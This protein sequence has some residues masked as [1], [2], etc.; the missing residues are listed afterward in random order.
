MAKEKILISVKTYPT[1]SKKYAE[2]VC[3]AGFR[4]NGSWV[5]IYPL[6]FRKLPYND[7]FKKWEWIE[8][9]LKKNKSDFR[10]ESFR[11]LDYD[12]RLKKIGEIKADGDAWVER[13][14]FALKKTYTNKTKLIKEAKNK[15][16][17]I[18]LATFRP[19]KILEFV[20]E[21]VSR[22]WDSNKL[23][24]LKQGNLFETQ[25]SN[26]VRKLPYKFSY[27]FIDEEGLESKLMIE[28]WEIG[29]LFWNALKRHSGNEEKACEDVKKKYFDNFALTK[30]LYLFLGTTKL[31]HF[32]ALNPFIII[33]VFYPKHLN[34][35][36][37]F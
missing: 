10:L 15:S 11:P 3:I 32:I 12:C 21:E 26:V 16:K 19:T 9:D 29:Q 24:A 17:P 20:I 1:L 4:E 36:K 37:L 23:E 22:E 31:N 25:Q 35:L 8:V 28:D 13:R 14:K 6:R 34:Q 2:L 18:S 5:R 7:Q 33:G 27:R 30:D